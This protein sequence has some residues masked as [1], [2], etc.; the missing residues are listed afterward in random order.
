MIIDENVPQNIV[1]DPKR[2]KQVI[3]NLIG[4]SLKFTFSGG[5]TVEV[6]V[7]EDMLETRCLDTGVGIKEEEMNSLFKSFGK[8]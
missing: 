5:I 6:S 2:Y 3:F 7:N 8:L 4:N 1:I